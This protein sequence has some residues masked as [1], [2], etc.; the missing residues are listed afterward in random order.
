VNP[1]LAILATTIA[2]VAITANGVTYKPFI[3]GSENRGEPTVSATFIGNEWKCG[4]ETCFAGLRL[5]D[6]PELVTGP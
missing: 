4:D 5:T 1:I 6:T 2:A 3:R